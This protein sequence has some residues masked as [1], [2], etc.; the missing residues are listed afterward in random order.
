MDRLSRGF[1]RGLALDRLLLALVAGGWAIAVAWLAFG[2]GDAGSQRA[3][4][5]IVETALDLIA[6]V[7]VLRAARSTEPGRVRLGW[8]VLGMATFVYALG[9]GAWLWLDLGGGGTDS[10]S[11]ADVAY[12][13]YYPIVVVALV[14]FQRASSSHGATLRFTIDSLIVVIGGGIVVWHTLFRPVLATLPNRRSGAAVRRRGNRP[15]PPAGDR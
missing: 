4:A 1:G 14:M 6:A 2:F 7:L 10:P 15:A 5:D 9:D 12:V 11:V 13:A 3:I 8:A